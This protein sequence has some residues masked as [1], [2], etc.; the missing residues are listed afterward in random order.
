MAQV[1]KDEVALT[2]I[3][4]NQMLDAQQRAIRE[5][6]QV[7]SAMAQ[8]DFDTRIRTDL[9]GDLANM[10]QAVNDSS[11]SVKVTMAALNDV[12]QSLHDGHFGV[13]IQAQVHGQFK[14]T[15][16]HA[17]KATAA[18]QA[19]MGEVG[20]V[21]SRVSQGDLTSRVQAAGRGEIRH[22]GGRIDAIPRCA[23]ALFPGSDA[24]R[25]DGAAIRRSHPG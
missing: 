4:F 6:N 9:R 15:L 20:Q 14:V 25:A 24:G 16:D 22:R 10:K 17:A 21:M 18:L 11:E 23:R 5:V 12:M 19:M 8:G 1:G 3:A 13:Q 2:A 7:V